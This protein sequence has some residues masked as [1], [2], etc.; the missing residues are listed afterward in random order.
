MPNDVFGRPVKV[1]DPVTIRGQVIEVIENPNYL[2]CKV[3]LNFALPPS[4]AETTFELN[5]A[6]LELE[7]A[8][9]PEP[10]A[11]HAQHTENARQQPAGERRPPHE[12]KK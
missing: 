5:T 4:G 9:N 12:S 11:Q 10:Q 7:T 2:N 1:D 8:G 3:K 6:Q